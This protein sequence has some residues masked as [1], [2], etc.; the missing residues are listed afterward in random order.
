MKKSLVLNALAALVICSAGAKDQASTESNLTPDQVEA[1]YTQAIEGRAADILKVLALTD[2]SKA[3]KVHDAVIAQ[4]RALKA[5]HDENDTRLK[6]AKSD[7]NA[8]AQIHASLQTLHD[9]FLAKLSANLTPQQVDQVKDKMTYGV[10][11]VTFN[12]YVKKYPDLTDAE[13][14][15][16]LTWLIEARESSMDQGSSDEKHAV[17]GKFKGRINNYLSKQGYDAKTGRKKVA[18]V[19]TPAAATSQPAK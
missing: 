12:A 1:K 8:V 6:A 18:P 13:K 14:Q 9:Y 2:T 17:F 10:V 16:L 15:Q 5:W 4:Y 3:A 11:Q 7:T 19:V